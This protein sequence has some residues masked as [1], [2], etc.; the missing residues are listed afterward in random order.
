ME[1]LPDIEIKIQQTINA[2]EGI[3]SAEPK[4]F[5]YTRLHARM[6]R[7]LLKPKT[8]LGWQFKPIYAVSA[9][10]LLLLI[11]IFTY[12][13]LEKTEKNVQEQYRLYESG[14]Y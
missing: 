11:N 13:N 14:G 7:E 4:A 8:V 1:N 10:L 12:I 3:E 6:A 2:L 5:F 9:V